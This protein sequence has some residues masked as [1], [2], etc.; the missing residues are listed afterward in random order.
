MDTVY[1]TVLWA[2]DGSDG[3]DGALDEARRALEPNGRLIVFHCDE[4]FAGGRV[5]GAPIAVDEPD[6]KAKIHEQVDALR[7]EGVDVKLSVV[8]THHG[9]AGEIAVAAEEDGAEVIVCG[10]RG[11]GS[12]AGVFAGSVA[13]R[14]PHVAG[15]PV[16]V[17]SERAARRHELAGA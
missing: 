3:A 10:T 2:T 5:G 1:K 14:L 8:V 6:R 11:L 15:C 16:L 9:P 17:V 4:R 12:V 13:M 7:A